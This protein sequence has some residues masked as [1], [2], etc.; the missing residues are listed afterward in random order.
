MLCIGSFTANMATGILYTILLV[1]TVWLQRQHGPPDQ[2][3]SLETRPHGGGGR[4]SLDSGADSGEG[5]PPPS[6]SV[7]RALVL[8][9][10]SALNT[11]A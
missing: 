8:S 6:S 1:Q 10:V 7:G 11:G 3:Q 9:G 5:L 4:V 2:S